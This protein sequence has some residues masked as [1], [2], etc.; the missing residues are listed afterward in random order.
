VE[1]S[2]QEQC[3]VEASREF[4]HVFEHGLEVSLD[5]L[6]VCVRGLLRLRNRRSDALKI[7]PEPDQPLLRTVVKIALDAASRLVA[8]RDDPR[9]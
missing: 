9:T 1:P 3:R 2:S 6:E 5:A 7:E 8:G 4:T